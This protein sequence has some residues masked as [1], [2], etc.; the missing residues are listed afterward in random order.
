MQ[1]LSIASFLRTGHDYHLFSYDTP[2]NVPPGTTVR[3]ARDILPPDSVFFY[4]DG[5]GKGSYSAFSN[6]FR[7]QLLFDHGGWWVDT[8]VICL[9]PLDD[10]GDY[11]LAS[12]HND[13]FTVNATTCVIR[14]PKGAPYLDYCVQVCREV[15]KDNVRWGEIGPDLFDR[16]VQ[17]FGLQ[18]HMSPVAAFNP[19][20]W[21][22]VGD[23]LAPNFDLA[24][25]AG[26]YAVHLYHQMWKHEGL[27][28]EAAPADSL[29]GWLRQRYQP[30][31]P[32]C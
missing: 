28:P 3:D 24:R 16:A 14:S 25:V 15:N 31:R 27:D 18:R 32:G 21:F 12:E 4:R 10:S 23:L 2:E 20:N 26:S 29:Y 8:D 9:K 19:I 1:E 5:F 7:Y 11:V 30:S 22:A 6:L 17:Q 13:D